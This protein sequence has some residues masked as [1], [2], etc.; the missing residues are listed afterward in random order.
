MQTGRSLKSYIIIYVKILFSVCI[1][2]MIGAVCHYF[3]SYRL[4]FRYL[5]I[6]LDREIPLYIRY[7][8]ILKELLYQTSWLPIMLFPCMIFLFHWMRKKLKERLPEEAEEAKVIKT[9]TE[10]EFDPDQVNFEDI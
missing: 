7:F 9:K 1:F 3:V 6:I 4:T 8:H 2:W 10:N 5:A